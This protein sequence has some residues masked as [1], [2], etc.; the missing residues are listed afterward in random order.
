MNERKNGRK[1]KAKVTLVDRLIA[2]RNDL[3]I[4]KRVMDDARRKLDITRYD[5]AEIAEAREE[6]EKASRDYHQARE[7]VLAMEKRLTEGERWT[8]LA[9]FGE[10]LEGSER[11]ARW[12]KM[13]E[14]REKLR[15]LPDTLPSK[16]RWRSPY[17]GRYQAQAYWGTDAT[18]IR[19]HGAG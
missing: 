7:R 11:T 19:G 2:A 3:A 12:R 16:P 18:S 5:P 13:E 6:W 17:W 4:D 9:V 8:Y 10:T 14:Q 1:R 15:R